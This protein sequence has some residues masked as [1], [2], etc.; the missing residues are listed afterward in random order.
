MANSGFKNK[1]LIIPYAYVD[2][3][4]TSASFGI[5][6][7][8]SNQLKIS[9]SASTGVNP[10]T[11][12]QITIDSA[13]NGD[14]TLTP[15]GSG[16]VN[17]D[18]ATQHAVPTYGA[19]GALSEIGPLTNGEL[20]IGSTGAQPVAA[21]LTSTGAT[22][23]ITAG[24]GSINLE[25]G[26]SVSNSFPTDSGTATPSSGALTIAGGTNIA[27]TGAGST[28]TVNFDGTLPV[29]SGG[30][31][32]ASLL[33]NA[34][35]VGSGAAAITPLAVG[36]D[37][38]VL[39]GST[40]AD[41]VFAT[42]TSSG[43]TISFTPGAGSLNLEASGGT[44]WSVET[45]AAVAGAVDSGFIANRAGL[46]TITLPT[47]AVIGS[48]IRVTG[49][50]TAVGWRIAQNAGETIYF[51]TDPTTT[52]VGGYLESTEIRD[53]VEIVCVVAD[54]DWNVLSSVGN[55]TVV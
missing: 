6:G 48:I 25:T 16:A 38:Q 40:A 45:D 22:V 27:T 8:D 11:A 10:T 47:T 41:P 32:A 2:N 14:I 30:T 5:D 29:G 51:G 1:D 9:T 17:I 12:V 49:I 3:S 28:V 20:V 7:N 37:G 46:V 18:Y 26:S 39:L 43:G 21:S 13:A 35:L 53:S 24:T 55:I 42:L 52:G 23:T 33:D 15:N 34:V 4:T 44:T 54:T 19:S 31:G 50:N 36:T